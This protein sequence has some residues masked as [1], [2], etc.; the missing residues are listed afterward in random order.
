MH[1]IFHLVFVLAALLFLAY[2]FGGKFEPMRHVGWLVVGVV[3]GILSVIGSNTFGH[4]YGNFV[5]HCVGG[6]VATAL[7]YNYLKL[8]THPKWSWRVDLLVMFG[9]VSAL[10]VINE[11]AEYA[12]ELAGVGI[13]SFDSHDTWRDLVAN[14]SGA[15]VT[16]L[17]IVIIKNL[18]TNQE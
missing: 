7:T 9:L 2:E 16:W 5:L 13:F 4:P 14:T 6:G 12:A 18:R 17:M 11:L 15:L 1:I 8:H 3:A 10:G